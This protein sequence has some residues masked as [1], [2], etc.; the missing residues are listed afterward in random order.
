MW[1]VKPPERNKT[2]GNIELKIDGEV[3]VLT[4]QQTEQ[5]KRAVVKE[6][7]VVAPK[8]CGSI[9]LFCKETGNKGSYPLVI[10]AAGPHKVPCSWGVG[11]NLYGRDF[12]LMEVKTFIKDIK[13]YAAQIWT[14]AAKELK[15]V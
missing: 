9:S 10:A 2:M 5:L 6:I 11:N 12:S 1:V 7:S 14:T 15:N 3:I 13:A 4:S 8:N